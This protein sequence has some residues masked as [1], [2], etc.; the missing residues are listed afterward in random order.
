MAKFHNFLAHLAQKVL[1]VFTIHEMSPS[2]ISFLSNL[3][4]CCFITGYWQNF[5]KIQS[6]NHFGQ[7]LQNF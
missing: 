6:N 7:N 1:L 4:F 3:V 5:A 2:F